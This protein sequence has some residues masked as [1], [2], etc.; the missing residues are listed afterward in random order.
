MTMLT[1]QFGEQYPMTIVSDSI[2]ELCDITPSV[3]FPR[4]LRLRRTQV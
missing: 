3:L 2:T 4:P 1:L